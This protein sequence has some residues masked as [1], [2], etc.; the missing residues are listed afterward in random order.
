[1]SSDGPGLK[2]GRAGIGCAKAG[3]APNDD[4]GLEDVS[5]IYRGNI[6]VVVASA[7]IHVIHMK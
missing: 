1:M 2:G 5:W 3:H 6:L 4:I 7:A